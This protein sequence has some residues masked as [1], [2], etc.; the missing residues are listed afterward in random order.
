MQKSTILSL[1]DFNI[2]TVGEHG[3]PRRT[4]GDASVVTMRTTIGHKNTEQA[5]PLGLWG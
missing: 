4:S 2:A 5:D 1:R 3:C